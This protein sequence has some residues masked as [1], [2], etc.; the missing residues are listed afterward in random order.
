MRPHQ[1]RLDLRLSAEDKKRIRHAA[2]RQGLPVAAFIR[3][4]A[5]RAAETTLDRSPDVHS[6]G[7]AARLRGRATTS[8]STDEIMRH[9]R[10][11]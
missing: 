7:L 4:A 2:A 11:T 5:L 10:G 3:Q 8:M 6:G 9:T 1:D